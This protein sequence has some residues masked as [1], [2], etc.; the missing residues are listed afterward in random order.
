MTSFVVKFITVHLTAISLFEI[1]ISD[2]SDDV[3]DDDGG[4][5]ISTV[6]L[7]QHLRSWEVVH[8]SV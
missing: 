5:A 3:V 7:L 8:E 1:F 6:V 2:S 4:L